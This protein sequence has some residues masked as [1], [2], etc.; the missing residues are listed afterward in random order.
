MDKETGKLSFDKLFLLSGVYA[1]FYTFCL[2]RNRMGLTFPVFALGTAGLFLYYLRLTGRA[3]KKGSALYLAGI[4]LLGL[5]VCLTSNEIVILLRL[6]SF[7]TRV[8]FFCSFLCFF[9]IICTTT[10]PGTC[11]NTSSPCAAASS[12]L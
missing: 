5:N 10:R 7:S 1:L 2:Y 4:L 3:L 6:S 11:Q 9:S 12:P 8:L